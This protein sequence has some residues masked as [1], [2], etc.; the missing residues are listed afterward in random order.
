VQKCDRGVAHLSGL[1]VLQYLNLGHC[2]RVTDKGVDNLSNLTGLQHSDLC[3]CQSVTDGGVGLLSGLTRLQHLIQCDIVTDSSE[4]LSRP[5]EAPAPA[6]AARP[7]SLRNVDR[8]R[9]RLSEG[10]RRTTAPLRK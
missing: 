10:P 8:K 2:Q 1:T 5:P 9:G 4:Y 3:Y 6:V 7:E